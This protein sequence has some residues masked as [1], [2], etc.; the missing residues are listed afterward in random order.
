MKYFLTLSGAPPTTSARLQDESEWLH[1]DDVIVV[2]A[3]RHI[4]LDVRLRNTGSSVVNLTRAHLHIL[5]RCWSRL[6]IAGRHP[7]DVLNS[8]VQTMLLL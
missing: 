3:K 2:T 8:M 7:D 6:H 5:G 4:E 1:V